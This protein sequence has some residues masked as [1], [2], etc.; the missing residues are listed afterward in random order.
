MKILVATMS[1]E[2]NTFSPVP[3]D[4]NRFGGGKVPLEGDAALA[5][6]RG[7]H[8]AMGGLI[9]VAEQRG[10]EIVTGIAASAPPSGPVQDDAYEIMTNKISEAAKDC[11]GILLEL[12]GAMVT[13]TFDDGEGTLLARLRRENQISRL[14][15][16]GYAHKPLPRD[17][18]SRHL[19]R[20]FSNLPSCRHEGDW[21]SGSPGAA[22]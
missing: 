8:T 20:R 16:A 3:T 13:D 21:T 6:I 17:G 12:H 10:V 11:D 18:R 7:T 1:H 4:L 14:A 2:T 22:Q 15:S 9:E 19:Y 5:A